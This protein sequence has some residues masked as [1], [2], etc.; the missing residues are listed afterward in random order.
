MYFIIKKKYLIVA[1]YFENSTAFVHEISSTK[2]IMKHW[3]QT[4]SLPNFYPEC[5]VLYLQNKLNWFLCKLGFTRHKLEKRLQLLQI[6]NSKKQKYSHKNESSS[7][8]SNINQSYYCC[9]WENFMSFEISDNNQLA[10]LFF[11]ARKCEDRSQDYVS[12]Q[13]QY[14]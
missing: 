3:L 4:F 1:I 7:W 5:T 2:C 11:K 8:Y 12:A 6:L 10:A 13:L 14:N 9:S